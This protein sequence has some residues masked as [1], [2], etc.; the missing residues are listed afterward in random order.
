M[1]SHI[2]IQTLTALM[3]ILSFAN[4]KI[5]AAEGEPRQVQRLSAVSTKVVTSPESLDLSLEQGPGDADTRGVNSIPAITGKLKP[6]TRQRSNPSSAG[7]V[8]KVS[9]AGQWITTSLGLAIV[10]G[11]ILSCAYVFRKHIP[12]ATKILPPDIVE[13]LGRRFIDQRNCVQLIRCGNRILIVAHSPTHGLQTLAEITDPIEVDSL[14]GRCRQSESLS[15]SRRF[16]ELVSQQFRSG[17]DSS[18]LADDLS[19][20]LP[21]QPAS[22]TWRNRPS[23]G[24]EHSYAP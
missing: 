1:P 18:P 17:E 15:T 22:R 21:G 20:V 8:K 14:A 19:E 2:W 6:P 24:K 13:V 23:S 11:L 4:G 10:I 9:P 12:L 5:D 3:M 16:E 7:S